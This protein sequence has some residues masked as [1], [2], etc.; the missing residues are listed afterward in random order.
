VSATRTASEAPLVA[1]IHRS[2][3]VRGLYFA[4]GIAALVAAVLGVVLPILP[5][6]PFV[7]LAAACFA[8]SSDRFYT[9]LL[10]HRI[11]G[12]I[13]SDW[14]EHGAMKREAKRWAL[15]MM[16]LSF[17]TSMLIMS[18]VWHRVMLVAM[19]LVL[20]ILIWRVPVRPEPNPSIDS[21]IPDGD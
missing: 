6:T 21:H 10:R 19:A 20:G 5:T 11:A 13:I 12:P 17:G 14:R 18:S 8:K 9:G 7:L 16:A 15:F 1:T 3:L 4:A 2:R